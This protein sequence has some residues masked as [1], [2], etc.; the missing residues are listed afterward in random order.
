M[1]AHHTPE[2]LEHQLTSLTTVLNELTTLVSSPGIDPNTTTQLQQ[3]LAG[4]QQEAAQ[5][6]VRLAQAATDDQ[7]F[8]S[9]QSELA[10]F[11]RK[12]VEAERQVLDATG[13]V[14]DPIDSPSAL[15]ATRQPFYRTP[16]FWLCASVAVAALGGV[17]Y[18]HLN[19]QPAKKKGTE[20]A[21][22]LATFKKP[23]LRRALAAR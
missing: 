6:R 14:Y 5:I 23:K 21:D 15:A 20:G 9:V 19:K 10:Q 18:Y 22:F 13:A 17:A 3:T 8:L 1:L 12:I 4:L 7:V 2:T 11:G 16:T